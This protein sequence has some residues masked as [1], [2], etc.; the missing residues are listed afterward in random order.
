MPSAAPANNMRLDIDTCDTQPMEWPEC[1]PAKTNEWLEVAD[2]QADDSEGLGACR[3]FP[4]AGARHVAE[5]EDAQLKPGLE[6]AHGDTAAVFEGHEQVSDEGFASPAP[7]LR[8]PIEKEFPPTQVS[9][10]S[11]RMTP[12]PHEKNEDF[13]GEPLSPLEA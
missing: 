11:V 6:A 4:K 7:N 1:K 5:L 3:V 2:T 12:T 9:L 13:L 10:P 8:E